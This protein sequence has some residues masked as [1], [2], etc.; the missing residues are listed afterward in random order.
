MKSKQF[1]PIG[2][3]EEQA[4]PV[5]NSLKFAALTQTVGEY[6]LKYETSDT[7]IDTSKF[8]PVDHTHDEYMTKSQLINLF[9]PVGSIYT[10]TNSENPANRFGGTWTQITDRFLYC[11]NSSKATG[12]SKKIFVANLPAHS[13][14]INMETMTAGIHSHQLTPPVNTAQ[15]KKYNAV[16]SGYLDVL[17]VQQVSGEGNFKAETVDG[18]KHSIIGDTQSTGS[19]SDY[20]PPYMTV[21]AWYRTA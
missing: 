14:H 5:Y 17:G 3:Y 18:H 19:G 11:A 12:G 7:V 16:S 8:A 4:V 9:Y 13:H 15:I 10:S 1:L 20:M 21:Y 2:F 6:M